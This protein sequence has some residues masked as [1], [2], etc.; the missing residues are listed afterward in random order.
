M[1]VALSSR[2]NVSEF[3]EWA[4]AQ[5]EGR[6]ELVAG[7]VI[8]MSP[9]RARHNLAKMSVWR[10]LS[11]ALRNAEASCTAYG[12]GMTVVIDENTSREPDVLVQ[13]GEP[14]DPDSLIADR[15]VIVVEVLSPSSVRA[16]TGEKLSDYFSVPTVHHY[17]IVNPLRYLVIHHARSESDKFETRIVETGDIKLSPPGIT[18]AVD[19]LFGRRTGERA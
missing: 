19:D 8:A 2:M 14:I 12:D 1:N 5:P 6:Y 13:C 18:V 4:E 15:P 11:D 16:D 3:L 17:L 9:E 7:E 10:A